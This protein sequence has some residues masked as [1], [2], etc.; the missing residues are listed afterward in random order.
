MAH[1]PYIATQTRSTNSTT[2]LACSTQRRREK[3]ARERERI[4]CWCFNR[5]HQKSMEQWSWRRAVVVELELR[6]WVDLWAVF[7]E[8]SKLVG[9]LTAWD[10]GGSGIALKGSLA[11]F[12]S[13]AWSKNRLR[14]RSNDH[15]SF[16]LCLVVEF[17][18]LTA[19]SC[20]WWRREILPMV[21]GAVPQSVCYLGEVL[22]EKK[23]R[24][25]GMVITS[26]HIEGR[27]IYCSVMQL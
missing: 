11:V 27:R 4:P 2:F 7:L 10:I 16:E 23:K 22:P 21:Y 26:V 3:R 17:E 6:H 12:V 25:G 8:I 14:R 19:S 9:D 1:D 5:R 24:R 20:S 13:L 18:V 15:C